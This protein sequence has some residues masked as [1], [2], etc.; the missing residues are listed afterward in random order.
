MSVSESFLSEEDSSRQAPDRISLRPVW[1]RPAALACIL[2]FHAGLLLAETA[3]PTKLTPLDAVDVT[4]EL[5]GDSV[6]D[7]AKQDEVT[8]VEQPPPTSPPTPS[9]QQAELTAP[10]PQ[11]VSPETIPLPVEK[12]KP[13]VK[14]KPE[15]NG[16][17]PAELRAQN[18]KAQAAAELGRKARE[19]RQAQRRGIVSG[20]RE[21]E[22]SPGSYAGLLAAELRRRQF[23]PTT[24]RAQGATGSVSVAFTVGPSG[25]I[26]RQTI[27]ASS[28]NSA[29]D[30]AARAM[31]SAVHTPPPPGG[32]F[33]TSTTIR[34][35]LN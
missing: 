4:L 29:L 10:S 6:M 24:A 16:P 17:T 34:F 32:R 9:V 19:A 26:L 13:V 12:A 31:M 33:S 5:E 27:T 35:H 7:Q 18:R 21:S 30:S 20:A 14:S 1:L 8:P 23:Y 22:M 15:H 3:Q 2:A 28:G 25:R 11:V